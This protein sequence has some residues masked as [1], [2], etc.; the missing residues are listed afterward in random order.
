[1]LGGSRFLSIVLPKAV[2]TNSREQMAMVDINLCEGRRPAC[3]G[4]LLDKEWFACE[5]V[6]NL[7]QL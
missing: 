6:K 4:G 7:E 5:W 1:M 3:Y 2:E